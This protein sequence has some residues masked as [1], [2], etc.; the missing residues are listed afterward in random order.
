MIAGFTRHRGGGSP[1]TTWDPA[2]TGSGAT[3]SGGNLIITKTSAGSSYSTTRS[4]TSYSSGKYYFE[5][6]IT[7]TNASNYMLVGI[8]NASASL[9]QAV[10][11]NIN[12]YSYYEQNGD[13]YYNNIG[14]AFGSAYGLGDVIG[15]AIDFA[16]GK[17]WF[18]KNNTWQ[19]SGNP[20]GG[21][22]PAYTITAG[23]YFAACS[24]WSTR[25]P[26][27][28]LTGQFNATEQT[29]TPPTGFATWGA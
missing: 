10:G 2:N 24:V 14:S 18:S 27:D 23:T 5:V 7:E 11:T 15:V 22:N 8:V 16:A 20:G 25:S 17:I 19:A 21:T 1:A 9:A 26:A 28:E 6:K 12:G 13:S 29:Y 4:T 3:L